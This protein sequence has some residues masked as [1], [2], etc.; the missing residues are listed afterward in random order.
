MPI[1]RLFEGQAFQPE[2]CQAMAVAFEAILKEFGLKDRT[3]PLCDLIA[4]TIIEFGQQGVRDSGELI[5][6]TRQKF[7][8]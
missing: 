1:Y 4:R 7:R 6:L 5:A 2:H 8:G 3:D